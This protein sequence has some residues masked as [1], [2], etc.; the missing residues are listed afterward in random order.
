MLES[1]D[2]SI[3]DEAFSEL[4]S[5]NILSKVKGGKTRSGP[6]RGYQL[7]DKYLTSLSAGF[8][9]GFISNAK[10]FLDKLSSAP[11]NSIEYSISFSRG[12]MAFILNEFPQGMIKFKAL[13]SLLGDECFESQEYCFPISVEY[14]NSGKSKRDLTVA[15]ESSKN[16]ILESKGSK[17]RRTQDADSSSP[18][19]KLTKFQE[20]LLEIIKKGGVFGATIPD[21]KVFL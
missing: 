15:T 21:I 12:E 4:N 2:P 16:T 20:S 17:K 3:L 10:S 5:A 11:S 13:V 18:E 7:S 1:I 9:Y 6:G 8:P 19:S 14:I